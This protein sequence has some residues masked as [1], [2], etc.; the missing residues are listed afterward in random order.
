MPMDFQSVGRL[1]APL[2]PIAGSILGG[3]IPFPGGSIIGQKLGEM[4]ASGF[5]V[6]PASP[7]AAPETE[8]K[9]KAMLANN[10]H[11]E[12]MATINAATE[13]ARMEIQ[14]FT[15]L[16]RE[17]QKTLQTSV[18]ETSTTER[19]IIGHEEHWFFYA[20]RPLTG[21][22]FAFFAGLFGLLLFWAALQTVVFGNSAPIEAIKAAWEPYAA[23]LGALGIVNGVVILARSQTQKAAIV[24]GGPL[25]TSVGGGQPFTKTT[26]AVAR[27]AIAKP[28]ASVSTA[29]DHG[30]V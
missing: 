7:T 6:N 8:A 5:G 3:L 20:W 22:E 16:E 10:Q 15:D 29:K 13:R 18:I 23:F 25:P 27:P 9:I 21:W 28:I 14:G 24:A 11:E 12:V 19:A 1:I 2:A 26:T 4:I 17:Y 30:A